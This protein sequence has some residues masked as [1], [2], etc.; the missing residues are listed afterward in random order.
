MTTH[1]IQS[2]LIIARMGGNFAD[3][4]SMTPHTIRLQNRPVAVSNL[5][6][7]VEILQGKAF[8]M[9][10]AIF[11]FGKVLG[12]QRMRGMTIITGC[13]GVM[14]G[15]LPPIIL[16]AHNVA[17]DTSFGIIGKIRGTLSVIKRVPRQPKE[18]A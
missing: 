5:N 16:I 6:R 2:L 13:D 17:I 11:H 4:P 3:Q 8:G 7:L 10:E 12:D 15:L 14:A 9:P 1:T 18:D